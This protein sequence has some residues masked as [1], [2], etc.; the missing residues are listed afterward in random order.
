MSYQLPE[1]FDYFDQIRLL[2]ASGFNTFNQGYYASSDTLW[3]TESKPFDINTFGYQFFNANYGFNTGDEL[4][5]K[6]KVNTLKGVK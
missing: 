5:F 6:I 3:T 4:P 1:E 2:E